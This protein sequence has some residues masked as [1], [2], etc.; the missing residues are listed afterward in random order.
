M[1]IALTFSENLG[2]WGFLVGLLAFVGIVSGAYPAFYVA[3]FQPVRILRGRLDLSTRRWF[4]HTL[5]TAQFVIA[6]LAVIMTAFLLMNGRFLLGQSWG[7]DPDDTFVVRLSDPD[8]FALLRDAAAGQATILRT[9]GSKDHIG[10]ARSRVTYALEGDEAKEYE[11]D[12][13][14]VGPDYAETLGLRLRS[15]RFFD[16]ARESEDARAVV[17]TRYFAD[18]R[19]WTDPLGQT[20]R[21]DSEPYTVIGV[22]EDF[23]RD[24]VQRAQPVLFRRA[25]T[26]YRF[27]TVRAAPGSAD[28]ARTALA[29]V[30][31][32]Y[33]PNLPFDAFAQRDVFDSQYASYLNLA[34]SIG[35]LA[36]LALLIACM[37]MFGLAS[38]NIARR[39]KEVSV[40]KVLGASVPHLVFLVNRA[41]L[42]ILAIAAGIATVASYG[43]LRF[44]IGLDVANVMPLTPLPFVLAYVLVLA[45]V[46]VSVASQSR[47]LALA[48]PAEVLRRN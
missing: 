44:L 25:D 30:W 34:R 1:E 27:L 2:L 35:Y 48:D 22:V 17:I 16:A 46:A 40:R 14:A 32:E 7:Y 10:S 38:Q 9:A 23:L 13:Y 4:T 18:G 33:L 5:T 12:A 31:A 36:A 42:M 37:G 20:L 45:T 39:L 19:G 26:G 6:F 11:A 29:R 43:G 8:Q 3:S 21:I 28:A 24:P 47:T 41:F 15:G